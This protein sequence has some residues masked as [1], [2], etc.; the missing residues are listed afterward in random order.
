MRRICVKHGVQS[1]DASY[2]RVS[3]NR[4]EEAGD[5]DSEKGPSKRGR[6]RR[7]LQ[8]VAWCATTVK[9]VMSFCSA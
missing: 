7:L 1:A 2:A 8:R 3:W 6:L 9:T 5:V 4:Y